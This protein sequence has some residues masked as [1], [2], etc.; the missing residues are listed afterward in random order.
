MAEKLLPEKLI[1]TFKI[2]GAHKQAKYKFPQSAK[3]YI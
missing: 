3:L 2:Y 1:F